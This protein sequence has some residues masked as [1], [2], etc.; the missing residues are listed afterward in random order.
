LTFS[1][2]EANLTPISVA[3]SSEMFGVVFQLIGAPG[4]SSP[5]SITGSPTLI[6]VVNWA[7]TPIPFATRAGFVSINVPTVCEIP[8]SLAA[9]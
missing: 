7:Y 5:V 2:N 1:W 9:R 6:E 3:D 4:E 8:D